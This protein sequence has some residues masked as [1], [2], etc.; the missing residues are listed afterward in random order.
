MIA[1]VLAFMVLMQSASAPPLKDE[2]K[3]SLKQARDL[4]YDAKYTDS[5]QVLMRVNDVLQSRSDRLSDKVDVKL[6]LSLANIGLNDIDKAK[7]YLIQMYTLDPNISL[8]AGE[9]S[10]K[11]ISLAGEAKTEIARIRC[12]AIEDDARTNLKEGNAAA[13]ARLVGS[14]DATCINMAAISVEATDLL[15]K[16]GLEAYKKSDYPTALMDF[17]AAVKFSPKHDLATQYVELT[18]GRLQVAV[19]RMLIEFQKNFEAHQLR[20]AAVNFRQIAG[21]N[22]GS[23]NNAQAIRQA[24][25]LYRKALTELVDSWNRTC[26]IGNT[27]AMNELLGQITELLPDP[28]FGEDLRAKMI[29]CTLPETRIAEARPALPEPPKSAPRNEPKT[30]VKGPLKVESKPVSLVGRTGPCL[31]LDYRV[32][33]TR[34]RSRV[35]PEIPREARP[36]I[37]AGQVTVRVKVRIDEDGVITSSEIKAGNPMFNMPV[38]SAVEQWKFSPA[39]DTNGTR[40]VDTE[41]PIVIGP[42]TSR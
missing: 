17:Q 1:Y 27:E 26:A 14:P 18:Q 21:L 6:Q 10:P 32:A 23:N 39:M 15:Y 3:E 13:I 24:T 22:N 41:I 30:E 8:D 25:E 5:V 19:E 9:Y 37:Q 40:C 7:S 38:R 2:I 29:P 31:Q 4:Y 28:T 11:V 42:L 34:L 33:M 16:S 20:D 36:V 35:D 12:Q